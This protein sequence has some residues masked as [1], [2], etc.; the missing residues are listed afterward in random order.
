MRSVDFSRCNF[1]LPIRPVTLEC[2][3][4]LRFMNSMAGEVDEG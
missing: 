1:A 2:D 3:L 4:H